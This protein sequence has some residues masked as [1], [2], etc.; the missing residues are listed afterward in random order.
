MKALGYH[1]GGYYL[2]QLLMMKE[3][4]PNCGIGDVCNYYTPVYEA[5]KQGNHKALEVL[6]EYNV[7]LGIKVGYPKKSFLSTA[8][9]ERQFRIATILITH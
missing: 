5:I 4:N 3:V 1:K 6:I 7:D 2:V 8:V 9:E